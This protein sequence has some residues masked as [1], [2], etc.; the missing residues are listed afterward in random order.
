MSLGNVIVS[1]GGWRETKFILDDLNEEVLMGG[2]LKEV[3]IELK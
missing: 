2:L 3:Q 1:F